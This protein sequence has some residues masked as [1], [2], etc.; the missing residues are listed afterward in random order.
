[1]AMT[2][3][4]RPINMITASLHQVLFERV[5]QAVRERQSIW[6]KLKRNWLQLAVAVIPGMGLLTLVMPWLVR[7][8]LGAGWE[9]TA[10]LIR[11]MMPWLTCIFLIA[12]LA[13]LSEVFGRQKLFLVIEIVYLALR[14]AA[15]LV[16]IGMND[17]ELAVILMSGVGTVVLLT[18]L[19]IYIYL[20]S[21]YESSRLTQTRE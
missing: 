3:A 15:M 18:Q 7:I 4:F 10:T 21:R 16:G 1:M 12:P 17:F 19:G 2:L 8:L 11:Y 13:F 9:E 20:L 14:I 6:Q 5:A